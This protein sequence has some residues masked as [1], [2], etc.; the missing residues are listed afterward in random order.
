VGQS[1][2]VGQSAGE[3]AAE[4]SNTDPGGVANWQRKTTAAEVARNSG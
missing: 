2:V 1:S 4:A 3:P